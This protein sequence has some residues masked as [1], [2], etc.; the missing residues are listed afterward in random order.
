MCN[1]GFGTDAIPFNLLVEEG[2]WTLRDSAA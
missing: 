2:A 1:S